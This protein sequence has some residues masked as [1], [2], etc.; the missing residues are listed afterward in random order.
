MT[1]YIT[2]VD[3]LVLK[4]MRKFSHILLTDKIIFKKNINCS[5]PE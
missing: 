5:K 4:R 3:I 2:Y 1:K